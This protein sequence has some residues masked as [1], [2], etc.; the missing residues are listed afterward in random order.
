M[1]IVI[2]KYIFY[3]TF[4]IILFLSSISHYFR[5]EKY[6]ELLSLISSFIMFIITIVL[7]KEIVKRF[8]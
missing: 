1:D 5:E 2:R 8:P 6:F 4:A 7:I 3:I